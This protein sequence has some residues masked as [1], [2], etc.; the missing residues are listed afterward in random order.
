[1]LG[2]GE[3]RLQEWGYV[4]LSRARTE[5]RL[6]VTGNP[7]EHESHFHDLDD[8]DPLTRFGRALE[9]SAGEEL[10]VD[11]RP[12]TSGPR[13]HARPESN[14]AA[15]PEAMQRRLLE[16][17]RGALQKTRD[18]AVRR[19]ENAQ[20]AP[21]R[22]SLL[23]RHRRDALRAGI[24]LQRHAIDVAEARL[25]ETVTALEDARHQFCTVDRAPGRRPNRTRDEITR[26][27][28]TREAPALVLE[29]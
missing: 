10:A 15:R 5:T 13:H 28:Q 11:Q 26:T 22:C 9:E 19:L 29:R 20:R 23:R 1:M 2:A 16:H 14:G 12:L 8:R 25:A 18:A 24:D 7:R 17:K 3:A 27:A 6:Y 21:N 4:A